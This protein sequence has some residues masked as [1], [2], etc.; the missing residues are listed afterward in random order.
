[1]VVKHCCAS[2]IA[3]NYEHEVLHAMSNGAIEHTLSA[4]CEHK[5]V[6]LLIVIILLLGIDLFPFGSGK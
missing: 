3:F 2:S 6:F 1:M 4:K 5:Y